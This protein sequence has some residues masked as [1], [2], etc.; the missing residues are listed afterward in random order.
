[1]PIMAGSKP[2]VAPRTT[3]VELDAVVLDNNDRPVR[4]VQQGD[5]QVKEDGRV[6]AVTSFRE[7][8]AVGIAG[9]ADGRSVVLLLDDH[10]VSPGATTIVQ[11][12]ARLFMSYARPAD[13]IAVVRLTHRED[14]AAGDLQA[15]H[16]RIDEYHAWSPSFFGRDMRDD[17]LQTVARVARQLV[18]VAHRRK[19]LVCIGNR[20]VCDPYF[21]IPENSLL[22]PSW[23]DALSA[24]ASAN[25]SVYAV[26]PA[27]L[28]SRIDLGGGLVDNSGGVAFARSNDFG[29][30]VGMIWNEAGHYYLLGYTP[31]AQPRDLHTIDVSMRRSGLRVRARR[32]RGD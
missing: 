17:A 19:V 22:W 18:P 31:T 1:M 14:E 30:A 20:D 15:A 29:R 8:S 26:S 27:G 12:I 24:A 4:G 16:D 13:T 9:R 28:G 2:S 7:V 11:H 10:A 5:F 25:A 23:R 32:R 21:Q 3:F 6:V